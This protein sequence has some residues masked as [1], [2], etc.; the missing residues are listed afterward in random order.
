[1]DRLVGLNKQ[2]MEHLSQGLFLDAKLKLKQAEKLLNF[3]KI[4]NELNEDN[5]NKLYILT[6]NNIGCYYKKV[7]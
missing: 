5:Y 3:V 1:M 7:F 2:G 4:S 6:M